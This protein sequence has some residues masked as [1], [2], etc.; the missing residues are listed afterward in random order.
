[1]GYFRSEDGARNTH[2][3]YG[4]RPK[5]SGTVRFNARQRVGAL[6]AHVGEP[7]GSHTQLALFLAHLVETT[8]VRHFGP[9]EKPYQK[10]TGTPLDPNRQAL[11]MEPD[12]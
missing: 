12:S 7:V 1:M 8:H 5:I 10:C 2:T 9:A 6:D 4:F 3:D 11:R